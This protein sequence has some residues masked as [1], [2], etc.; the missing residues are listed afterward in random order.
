[1]LDELEYLK[2]LEGQVTPQKCSQAQ[3]I[4]HDLKTEFDTADEFYNRAGQFWEN[5][6]NNDLDEIEG[7]YMDGMGISENW[8]KCERCNDFP[9]K[10]ALNG[11]YFI[12]YNGHG[13]PCALF[14][15][16]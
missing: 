6:E 12:N 10:D 4:L 15:W 2:Q 14:T 11:E 16:E 3:N 1:M 13:P 7:Q 5:I 8:Q 9:D